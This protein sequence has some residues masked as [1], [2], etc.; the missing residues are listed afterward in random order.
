[1]RARF[2]SGPEVWAELRRSCRG[3]SRVDAAIAYLASD[4]SKLLKLKK[5]DVLP[6]YLKVCLKAY[7]RPEFGAFAGTSQKR[8]VKSGVHG[9]REVAL[10]I[11]AGLRYI[12]PAAAE[13]G[14]I[15]KAEQRAAKK[16]SRPA[17]SVGWIRFSREPRFFSR[18]R[19]GQDVVQ[20]FGGGRTGRRLWPPS[21]ILAV[22]RYHFAPKSPPRALLLLE[23]PDGAKPIPLSLVLR[24]SRRCASLLGGR[25]LISKPI[26]DSQTA[27]ALAE[28]WTPTGRARR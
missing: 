15:E 20:A 13:A 2:L 24:R 7:R 10:R 18:L 3:Q 5:G 11:I 6:E 28:L 16:L 14:I 23:E 9:R 8:G 4:G 12:E 21:K 25:R 1:M 22:E 17:S 19:V 26:Y 27:N